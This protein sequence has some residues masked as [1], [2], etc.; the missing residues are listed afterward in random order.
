MSKYTLLLF[1]FFIYCLTSFEDIDL[2][3]KE[4]KENANPGLKLILGGNKSDLKRVVD[5]EKVNKIMDE[6]DI[7]LYI[8]TSARTGYNVEKL[9]VEASKILFKEYLL[10]KDKTKKKNSKKIILEKDD[11]EGETKKECAC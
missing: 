6:C 11:E 5:I 3:Y 4:I 7:D 2:W 10:I 9:F 8:E 1:Y